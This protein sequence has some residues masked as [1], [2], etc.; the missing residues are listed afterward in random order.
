MKSNVIDVT[1]P[2]INKSLDLVERTAKT[3]GYSDEFAAKTRLL[4]EELINGNRVIIEDVKATLWVETDDKN[5]EI[6][7]RL[8]GGLSPVTRRKLAELSLSK[9]T[10]PKESLVSRIGAF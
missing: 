3:I 10:E 5:M 6:H 9:C 7:L 2:E 4:T 8:Q 1:I